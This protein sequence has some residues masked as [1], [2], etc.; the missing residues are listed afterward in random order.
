MSNAP[1]AGARMP[2]EDDA[3]DAAGAGDGLKAAEPPKRS[4][5]AKVLPSDR[6]AFEN[7]LN[8]LRAYVAASIGGTKPCS[9]SEVAS[10][11]RFNANTVSVANPFFTSTGLVERS[12]GGFLPS[13]EVINFQRAYEWNPH[14]A[15]QKLGPILRRQWFFEAL[16]PRLSFGPI[17]EDEAIAAL[18]DL[19]GAGKEYKGN[20]KTLLD[21]LEASGLIVR[22]GGQVK[23]P[24]RQQEDQPIGKSPINTAKVEQREISSGA[25]SGRIQIN[26]AIDLDTTQ[27]AGWPPDRITAFFGGLAQVIAAKSSND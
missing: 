20:L 19:A 14:T 22:D 8:V 1:D 4:K 27:I 16:S 11:V 17:S 23:M 3:S 24:L 5:P 18:A 12:E 26:V 15:A 13:V 10:V 25:A 2:W 6:I 9:L 7:Q 21:Y